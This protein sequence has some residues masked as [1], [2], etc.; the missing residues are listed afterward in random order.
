[1]YSAGAIRAILLQSACH[2]AEYLVFPAF[3]SSTISCRRFFSKSRAL[4]RTPSVSQIASEGECHLV[5]ELRGVVVVFDLDAVVGVYARAASLTIAV[6]KR[7]LAHTVVVEDHRK[8]RLRTPQNLS[9]EARRAAKPAIRLPSVDDPRFNLQFLGGEPLYAYAIEE[10]WRVRRHVRWLVGPVIEVVVTEQADIGDEDSSINVQAIVHI[11]VVP[12][13]CF[14]HV[15]VR[16][17]KRPL[18]ATRAGIISWRRDAEHSIDGQH[19]T[20]DVLPVEVASK[21]DLLQ[22]DFIRPEDLGRPAQGVISRMVVTID[23]LGVESD[24]RGEEF[25]VKGQILYAGCAIEPGP[26]GV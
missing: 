25:R 2:S 26:V 1:M 15:A 4:S 5:E 10:P 6:A 13:P 8:P 14:R 9:S 22:L 23:K 7:I 11:P 21:A 19:A 16:A 12:A 17:A 20:T 18:A 24:F 3:E